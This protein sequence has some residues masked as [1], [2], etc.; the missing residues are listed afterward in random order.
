[1]EDA[2]S[3]LVVVGAKGIPAAEK[4]GI[5]PV[6]GLAINFAEGERRSIVWLSVFGVG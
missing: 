6:I 3:K 1:M 2:G 5:A 4:T